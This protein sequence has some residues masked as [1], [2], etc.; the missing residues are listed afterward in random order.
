MVKKKKY[1]RP[2]HL[3]LYQVKRNMRYGQNP[4]FNLSDAEKRKVTLKD[5]TAIGKD[6]FVNKRIRKK[7]RGY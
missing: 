2:K 1:V 4:A 6:L 3:V 7:K 5:Y